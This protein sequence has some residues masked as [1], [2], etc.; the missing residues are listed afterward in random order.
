MFKDRMPRRPRKLSLRTTPIAEG[1]E[2]HRGAVST[3]KEAITL[4]R[5]DLMQGATG[6]MNDLCGMMVERQFKTGESDPI[7]MHGR[8]EMPSRPAQLTHANR[9]FSFRRWNMKPQ[10]RLAVLQGRGWSKAA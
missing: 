4:H 8:I 5:A 9:H 2:R 7:T 3:A 1:G 6:R 10:M